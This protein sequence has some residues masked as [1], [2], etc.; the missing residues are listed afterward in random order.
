MRAEQEANERRVV[1]EEER[2]R[3]HAI[4]SRDR[5]LSAIALAE[6]LEDYAMHCGDVVE[7]ESRVRW[8]TPYEVDDYSHV[9]PE[10]LDEFPAWPDA[11]DWKLIG[12]PLAQECAALRRAVQFS[13]VAIHADADNLDNQD[14]HES[15]AEK[16]LTLGLRAWALA[17]RVRETTGIAPFEANG[18]FSPGERLIVGSASLERRRGRGNGGGA[19][20]KPD[21]GTSPPASPEGPDAG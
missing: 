2:D 10:W 8:A 4:D 13:L 5:A 7:S 21:E 1:R 17:E 3:L 9:Q 20:A 6:F 11:V 14:L 18:G 19:A 12:V 15:S 16:A